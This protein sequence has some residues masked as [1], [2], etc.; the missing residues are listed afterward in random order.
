MRESFRGGEAASGTKIAAPAAG[1]GASYAPRVRLPT[2][3]GTAQTDQP[4]RNAMRIPRLLLPLALCTLAAPPLGAQGT[5]TPGELRGMDDYVRRSLATWKVAGLSIAVVK[6]DSVVY[7]RG[8]GVRDVGTRAPV[9]EHTVFAIGSMTKLF[10]AVAAGMMVDS[11]AMQWDEPL[12]RHIPTFATA[13]PYATQHLSLRDALSHRSG[14]DWRLDFVWLGTPLTEAQVLER[15]SRFSPDPGFRRGYGYSNVMFGAAGVAVGNA[16]GTGWDRV[17]RERI[18]APLGMRASVTG[19]RELPAGGNVAMPHVGY[20]GEP[21]R[22]PRN[23]IA[24]VRAAGAINSSA[25]DMAQWLRFLLARGQYRGRRLI[26]EETFAEIVSPQTVMPAPAGALRPFVNFA[27]YGLGTELMDYRGRKVVHHGGM[28]DGMHAY[29]AVVPDAKVGV[30][31]LS[32]TTGPAGM[33]AGL[34]EAVT[35]RVLDA[36]LGG[37]PTDWSAAFLEA[38][39]GILA[40]R[41]QAQTQQEAARVRGPRPTLALGD[42]AGR[43][44]GPTGTATVTLEGDSLRLRVGPIDSRLEHWHYDTFRF[45]WDPIGAMLANFTLNAAGRVGGL[46]LGFAGDFERAPDPPGGGTAGAPQPVDVMPGSG[47]AFASEAGDRGS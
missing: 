30:V 29:F 28:V 20:G 23:D 34:P 46:H 9:D 25:V 27:L 26:G 6:D 11:G 1:R 40:R 5:G 32:N 31:V 39:R 43:Y 14:L 47:G 42:Y 21:R 3:G 35:F 7:A 15:V 12:R 10:T 45:R 41:A 18:F 13:D 16:A 19:V 36:Y 38:R 17:V 33:P 4:F 22:V 37:E 2:A 8:F 24:N 44:V